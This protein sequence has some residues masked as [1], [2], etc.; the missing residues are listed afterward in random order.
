MKIFTLYWWK[1]PRCGFKATSDTNKGNTGMNPLN[2][3]Q[4]PQT[5]RLDRHGSHNSTPQAPQRSV[6]IEHGKQDVL[7]SFT[8]GRTWSKLSE[9]MPQR[10]YENHQRLQSQQEIQ[11]LRREGSQNKGE[12]SHNTGYRGAMDPERE[13]SDSLKITRSRTTQLSSGF[14]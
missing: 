2:I 1:L 7:S 9:D 14:T 8:L 10:P 13:Y 5:R 12:S 4:R 6:S 11:T 3:Q